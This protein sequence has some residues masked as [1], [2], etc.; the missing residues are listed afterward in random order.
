MELSSQVDDLASV[1]SK[2]ETRNLHLVALRTEEHV[3]KQAQNQLEALHTLPPTIL[4]SLTPILQQLLAGVTE[5]KTLQNQG[6]SSQSEFFYENKRN[7][8][9]SGCF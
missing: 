4:A 5:I 9:M 7:Q 3:K 2:T 1:G 8:I 6:M